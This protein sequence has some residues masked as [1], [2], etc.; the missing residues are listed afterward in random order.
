MDYFK[1]MQN[2]LYNIEISNIEIY[3][4]YNEEKCYHKFLDIEGAETCINCGM[5]E[6][7]NI[8]Y[9]INPTHTM[10]NK[11]M[12]KQYTP[13]LHIKEIINRLSGFIFK[14]KMTIEEIKKLLNRKRYRDNIKT[15]KEVRKFIK[16]NN[17]CPK[18]DFYIYKLVNDI[19][20]S[21]SYTDK[22]NYVKEYMQNH[23]K[24]SNR[25]YLYKKFS[26]KRE[27]NIFS[28]LFKRKILKKKKN[29]RC[30]YDY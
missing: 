5:V 23:G 3:E 10:P 19:S 1:A 7:Y 22:Q 11:Q 17:L 24:I 30:L 16:E 4:D 13:K 9:T 20:T 15:I 25:D 8:D 29:V 2:Y 28:D 21:I 26:E 18:N 14:E 6:R 12:I 27:Y